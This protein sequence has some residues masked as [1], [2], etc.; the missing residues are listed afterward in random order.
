ML[1]VDWNDEIICS[2]WYTHCYIIDRH[3]CDYAICD[4]WTYGKKGYTIKCSKKL[5]NH[6]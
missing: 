1:T 3:G 2:W 6:G 4:R 5:R